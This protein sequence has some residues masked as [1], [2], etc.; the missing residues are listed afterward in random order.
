METTSTSARSDA[1]P[2]IHLRSLL[3]GLNDHGYADAE[4]LPGKI[5]KQL[6]GTEDAKLFSSASVDSN[7]VGRQVPKH[8]RASLS[9]QELARTRASRDGAHWHSPNLEGTVLL[10]TKGVIGPFTTGHLML[11]R[12]RNAV[13]ERT[14]GTAPPRMP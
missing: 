9:S 8:A 2:L 10:N 11:P 6:E 3:I 13:E 1:K 7:T 12:L 4:K 5:P 14:T